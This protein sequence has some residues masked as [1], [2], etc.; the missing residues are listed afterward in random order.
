MPSIKS[1]AFVAQS[2]AALERDAKI[3]LLLL[4]LGYLLSF[5]DRVIFGLVLKPIKQTLGF[6]DSQLG[7]LSGVAFAASYALLSPLAGW[8]VDRSKR[9]TI[10]AGAIAFWS[11]MTA[12][13]GLATNFV[14]MGLAR[15]GVG[16]GEA[17]L[18]PLSVSL[19][20]DTVPPARR[21]RA[22]AFYMSAGAVGGMVALLFGGALIRALT[23]L[24]TLR[25]PLIGQVQPWEGLFLSA[26]VPGFVLAIVI[27]LVMREPAR[28]DRHIDSPTGIASSTA[29]PTAH[30]RE[31]S[32]GAIAF[33]KAHPA[34]C[35][36]LFPG[37]S[38]IQMAAYTTTTWK[39]VFFERAHGWSGAEAALWLGAVGGPATIIGCLMSGRIIG[40]MR[41]RG[42][43]DAPLR[44]CLFSCAIYSVSAIAGLL[45]P[46]P[47]LSLALL[48][49]AF[50]CGYVP[51]V[52]GFSAMGEVLPPRT[53]ARLAGLHTLTNGLIANSL[54]PF[55]V[56][57]FSDALF[58]GA[59]GI[60]YAMIM[61]VVIAAVLGS[62]SI[63][64]GIASYRTVLASNP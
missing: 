1:P 58:P 39:I 45:A 17:F 16:A 49:G 7:L 12:A 46:N 52:A 4:Y 53:R 29:A 21:A 11:L 9:R 63:A 32:L 57:F 43:A 10:M 31:P 41:A 24:G 37:I 55:L 25:L 64:G 13:T 51:S 33:L 14:T 22:F 6:S 40:W 62:L 26:A 60:R 19:V 61:T 30:S 36:A 56:G 38:L 47:Y 42:Y 18:H 23:G 15:M 28:S 48:S 5:A 27:L 44:L 20:S 2:A 34:L 54:G 3:I 8:L 35:W 59:D 50:F